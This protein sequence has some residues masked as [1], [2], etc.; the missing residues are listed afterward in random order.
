F[1]NGAR[2]ADI[3]HRRLH[4]FLFRFLLQGDF[5]S[6]RGLPRVGKYSAGRDPEI[7]RIPLAPS[8]CRQIT[9]RI[10][11]ANH[12]RSNDSLEA[13][14]EEEPG[15]DERFWGRQSRL[16]YGVSETN[17]NSHKRRKIQ[18]VGSSASI[19]YVVAWL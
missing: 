17:G 15:S 10:P 2:H 9:T 6:A 1:R 8:R 14:V 5:Q 4:L 18:H 12:V 3:S 16:G 13:R 19:E 11:A 7:R